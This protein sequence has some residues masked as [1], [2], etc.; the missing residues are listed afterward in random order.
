MD[1]AKL[2]TSFWLVVIIS[3]FAN[4]LVLYFIIKW[5][6]K[7]AIIESRNVSDVTTTYQKVSDKSEDKYLSTAQ[8]ELKGK[9]ERSEITLEE[10]QKEWN[11][12]V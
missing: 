9:Y 5:A 1:F 2:D 12:L 10:Y 7:N 6:V 8:K 3:F 11:K 4:C